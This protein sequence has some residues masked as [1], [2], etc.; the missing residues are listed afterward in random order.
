M[1]WNQIPQGPVDDDNMRCIMLERLSIATAE[2]GL[3]MEE[4]LKTLF[5]RSGIRAC[6][7]LWSS[8]PDHQTFKKKVA[9]Y[10][11][12]PPPPIPP[13]AAQND[14][15][16]SDFADFAE[17]FA[18]S[19]DYS[20]AFRVGIPER[21]MRKQLDIIL[22]TAQFVVRYGIQFWDALFDR[23]STQPQFKFLDE[24]DTDDVMRNFFYELLSGYGHLI[25]RWEVPLARMEAVLEGFSTAFKDLEKKQEDDVVVDRIETDR[26][27]FVVSDEYFVDIENEDL[28]ISAPSPIHAFRVGIPQG[29]MMH[30]ELAIIKFTALFVVRYGEEFWDALWDSLS[31]QTE[32]Q[33]L[34]RNP[35]NDTLFSQLLLAYKN[36]ISPWEI[37]PGKRNKPARMEAVLEGFFT[38]FNAFKG[39]QVEEVVDKLVTDRRDFVVG[40]EYFQCLLDIEERTPLPERLQ[41]ES[42]PP[43]VHEKPEPKVMTHS[44]PL[45][46]E[47]EAKREKLDESAFVSEEEFLA[48]HP[49]SSTITISDPAERAIEISVQSFCGKFE[50]KNCCRD[51]NSNKPTQVKG[52][53][54]ED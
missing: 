35:G 50:E 30:K 23:V 5:G 39:K 28:L 4:K 26:H 36:V 32:F 46:E 49:G 18:L 47:P 31:T 2:G 37:P 40:A 52:E 19:S 24:K 9:E 6:S 17:Q 8:D 12:S 48:Q 41:M 44:P 54:I 14:L 27:D 10:A 20:T 42:P 16:L 3:E 38:A 43:M 13:A 34:K 25:T 11:K 29:G 53:N 51:G 21:M 22:L 33:F 1:N 7:F 45:L 15:D